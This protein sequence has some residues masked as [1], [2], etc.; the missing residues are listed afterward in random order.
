VCSRNN[1]RRAASLAA[2]QIKRFLFDTGDW[3]MRTFGAS[4]APSAPSVIRAVEFSDAEPHCSARNRSSYRI[5]DWWKNSGL[6][7]VP[8]C[9][10][11]SNDLKIATTSGTGVVPLMPTLARVAFH[12]EAS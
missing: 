10:V 8:D 7:E 1:G 3:T 6:T 12:D 11:P 2:V 9:R 5:P 4:I